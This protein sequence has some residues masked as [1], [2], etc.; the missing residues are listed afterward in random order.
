MIIGV[1]ISWNIILEMELERKKKNSC[2]NKKKMCGFCGFWSDAGYF[3][4]P[5]R[6]G[7]M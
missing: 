3:I 4:I 7:K 5:E 1:F 2:L 6:H